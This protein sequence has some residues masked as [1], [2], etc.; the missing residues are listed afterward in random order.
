[1]EELLHEM[2]RYKWSILGLCEMR[3]K[4]S[5]EIP[6]DGGHRVYF[7]G[8]EYKREQGVGFLVHKVIMK[9]VIVCRP[10]SNRHDSIAESKPFQHY[11]YSG[12]CTNI[13]LWWHWSWWVLHGTPVSSWSNTKAGHSS[14]TRWLERESWKRCTRRLERS[15]WNFLSSIRRQWQR[16]K[17]PKLRNLQQ[18]CAGK[19]PRQP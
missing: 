4:K 15:L 17:A 3:W 13:Q 2:D 7:S 12:I 1:M 5:G 10:I 16:A 8:K 19:H 18:P 14:C 9:S 6:T 11:H